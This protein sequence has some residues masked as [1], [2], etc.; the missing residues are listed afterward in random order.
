M[1][2]WHICIVLLFSQWSDP[3]EEED[4]PRLQCYC[5]TVL[6]CCNAQ[7]YSATLL[8]CTMLVFW[9]RPTPSARFPLSSEGS[10]GGQASMPLAVRRGPWQRAYARLLCRTDPL[11]SCHPLLPSPA[12]VCR[13]SAKCQVPSCQVAK[14]PSCWQM[15]VEE[16]TPPTPAWSIPTGVRCRDCSA[17]GW[18]DGE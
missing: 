16:T 14:L 13:P 18:D 7:C 6:Q 4:I 10:L 5:V 3:N 17:V 2:Q 1:S 11:H 12:P 15:A 9:R 8:Q